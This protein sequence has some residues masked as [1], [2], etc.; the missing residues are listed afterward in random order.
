[1]NVT[2]QNQHDSEKKASLTNTLNVVLGI[3]ISVITL[4]GFFG[5]HKYTDL[6]GNKLEQET[7]LLDKYFHETHWKGYWVDK[8]N[9]NMFGAE[10]DLSIGNGGKVDGTITWTIT[11]SNSQYYQGKIGASAFEVVAGDFNFA[12]SKLSLTGVSR[13]DPDSI[14]AQ[15]KYNLK[16]SEDKK[17][18]TG[19]DAL[20]AGKTYFEKSGSN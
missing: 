4:L 19:L 8:A 10:M 14:I 1:M 7:A 15:S 6:F 16:L 3:T 13:I 12:N 9:D 17:T 5:I 2:S 11:K 18:L 20:Q